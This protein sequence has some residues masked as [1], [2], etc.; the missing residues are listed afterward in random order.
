MGQCR[1]WH[2]R[3]ARVVLERGRVCGA[4][5][6]LF[7][8]VDRHRHVGQAASYGSGQAYCGAG[9]FVLTQTCKEK[10]KVETRQGQIKQATKS[11]RLLDSKGL[12][13]K[14]W[15]CMF[16]KTLGS[17]CGMDQ[18][19]FRNR[20]ARAAT[21]SP[22]AHVHGRSLDTSRIPQPGKHSN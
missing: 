21:A 16:I 8:C 2:V 15:A 13:H 9:L 17:S 20:L 5:E 19:S 10:I 4:V 3:S 14:S 12:R 11:C 22:I 6:V 1:L 7:V 18:Q